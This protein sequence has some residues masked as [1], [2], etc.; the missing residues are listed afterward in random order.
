MV[1]KSILQKVV[2]ES[3]EGDAMKQSE[4]KPESSS[5]GDAGAAGS[6]DAES[7]V[8]RRDGPA[9]D[10]QIRMRAYELYRE[11]GGKVGDDMADWLRAECEYLERAPRTTSADRAAQPAPSIPPAYRV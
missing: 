4:T 6:S 8:S 7:G 9:G 1:P 2:T 10:E 3:T 11:R 5:A